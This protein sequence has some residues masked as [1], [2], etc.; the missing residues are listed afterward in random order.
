MVAET[1]Q[2]RP[3]H[4]TSQQKGQPGLRGPDCSSLLSQGR[5]GT[6]KTWALSAEGLPSRTLLQVIETGSYNFCRMAVLSLDASVSEGQRT[7]PSAN[8]KNGQATSSNQDTERQQAKPFTDGMGATCSTELGLKHR[9]STKEE[10]VEK[11]REGMS[12][13]LIVAIAGHDPA[14]LEIWNM[15]TGVPVQQLTQPAGHKHG[16]CM[17]VQLYTQKEQSVLHA[18][19]GYEDGTVAVWDVTAGRLVKSSQLHAEPVMALAVTADGS[20]GICAAADNKV[21]CF[22]LGSPSTLL[23]MLAMLEVKQHGIADICIRPDQRLFATAGWDGKVRLFHHKK[24]RPLAILQYHR[25]GVTA[26]AF[27]P[28]NQCLISASRDGTI[29]IWSVFQH[30]TI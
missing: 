20:G 26:L 12:Q 30:K 25:K 23:Q 4:G 15:Q 6:I 7:N 29:A 27:Q 11:L 14:V 8:R 10:P 2:V 28:H 3:K 22:G 19:V 16:M 21:Q 1:P 5:D 9:S 13:E 18:L 17:A 24:M